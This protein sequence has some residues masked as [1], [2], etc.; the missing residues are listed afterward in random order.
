ML[1]CLQPSGAAPPNVPVHCTVRCFAETVFDGDASPGTAR[2][3]T[4]TTASKLRKE[5]PPRMPG[6]I[7][8]SRSISCPALAPGE[9]QRRVVEQGG[10]V[11]KELRTGLAVDD[12]VVERQ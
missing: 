7:R 5:R 1:G 9:E 8:R 11:C 12:P 2:Q 3:A 4:M 10:D 6:K